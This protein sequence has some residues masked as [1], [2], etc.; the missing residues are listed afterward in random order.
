MAWVSKTRLLIGRL[1][2]E[3]SRPF[4]P[5][6]VLLGAFVVVL[7]HCNMKIFRGKFFRG[8]VDYTKKIVLSLGKRHIYLGNVASGNHSLY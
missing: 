1:T 2:G 7:S 4:N 5:Q 6:M 8:R 3:N